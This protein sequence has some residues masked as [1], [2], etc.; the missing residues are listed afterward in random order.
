[1]PPVGHRRRDSP[2]PRLPNACR[3]DLFVHAKQTLQLPCSSPGD[4]LLA[5]NR[6]NLDGHRSLLTSHGGGG[7]GGLVPGIVDKTGDSVSLV[8][9]EIESPVFFGFFRSSHE[10]RSLLWLRT[11]NDP[12]TLFWDRGTL[13]RGRISR[14]I[15]VLKRAEDL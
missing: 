15:S 14:V 1:M 11:T 3:S 5:R 4:S 7:P 10:F 6:T 8:T 2:R 12:G 13:F 9:G